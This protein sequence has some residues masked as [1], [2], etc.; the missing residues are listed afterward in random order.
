M[1]MRPQWHGGASSGWETAAM[2]DCKWVRPYSLLN[3]AYKYYNYSAERLLIRS[4]IAQ[5]QIAN[6]VVRM[7]RGVK[8]F[9]RYLHRSVHSA[10]QNASITCVNSSF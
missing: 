8:T 5:N 7:G 2:L 4:E 10:E 3:E 1:S 6:Y 9:L